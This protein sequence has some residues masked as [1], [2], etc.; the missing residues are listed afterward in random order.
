MHSD[1]LEGLL[2]LRIAESRTLEY[3]VG[4]IFNDESAQQ[5]LETLT[6]VAD[7]G[8]AGG[9]DPLVALDYYRGMR[10]AMDVNDIRWLGFDAPAAEI[11]RLR[12]EYAQ[13]Y[14]QYRELFEL[15]MGIARRHNSAAMAFA[16]DWSG[17][18]SS[19]RDA[20]AV[21]RFRLMLHAAGL[22]FRLGVPGALDVCDLGAFGIFRLLYLRPAA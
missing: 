11:K 7:Q 2:H 1:K 20:V 13:Q 3:Q 18:G 12:R 6:V 10:S 15:E 17:I 16:R 4:P 8:E 19:L 5:A 21:W 9:S 14:R 22:M